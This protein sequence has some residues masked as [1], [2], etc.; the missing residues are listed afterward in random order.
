LFIS[1]N[2][3]DGGTVEVAVGEVFV[4]VEGQDDVVAGVAAFVAF[5]VEDVVSF[6]VVVGVAVG[7]EEL[8]QAAAP[9][10]VDVI[11]DGG[12]RV[13]FVGALGDLRQPISVIPFVF[14]DG[15]AD[16]DGFGEAIVRES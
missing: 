12:G 5:A 11:K 1:E 15:T 3:I 7:V 6:F 2:L 16:D 9:E 4:G 10:I 13:V 8:G 14:F